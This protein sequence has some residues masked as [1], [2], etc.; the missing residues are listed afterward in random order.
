VI[1]PTLPTT[2]EQA[3][4]VDPQANVPVLNARWLIGVAVL[5]PFLLTAGV[6]WLHH[7][8]DGPAVTVTDSVVEVQLIPLRDSVSQV[9][10]AALPRGQA[11]PQSESVIDDPNRAIPQEP[12]AIT[13]SVQ[14]IPAESSANRS[15]SAVSS[16]PADRPMAQSATAFQQT[17]LRHIA[18]FRYYPDEARRDQIQGTVQLIFAMQRNGMVM[19]VWVKTTSGSSVLDA[20]AIETVRKAQPMPR[21]PADLPNQLNILIPVAFGL[22]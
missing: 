19:D 16:S 7:A 20:A 8:P 11:P 15:G 14:P 3:L 6:Y 10:E 4:E 12:L 9:R 5:V 22:P 17:L 1:K 18:R 13:P 21:I 2:T